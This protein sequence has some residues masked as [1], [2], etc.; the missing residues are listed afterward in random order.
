MLK[1][2]CHAD[3]LLLV[4]VRC[5]LRPQELC[6]TRG[7]LNTIIVLRVSVYV[8]LHCTSCVVVS[9]VC[10]FH[11]LAVLFGLASLCAS[12]VLVDRVSPSPA[13]RA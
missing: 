7:G 8:R 11:A 13:P 5:V 12:M 10:A 2:I 9:N 3:Y 1:I 4:K 6:K